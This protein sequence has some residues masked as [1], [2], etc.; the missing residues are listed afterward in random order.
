MHR[1]VLC[2]KPHSVIH[3]SLA[4][5]Q[6]FGSNNSVRSMVYLKDGKLQQGEMSPDD[7]RDHDR[8]PSPQQQNTHT[9]SGVR[10]SVST[11]RAGRQL[12]ASAAG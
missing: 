7:R 10:A 6:H 12:S 5:Q 11:W 4:I 1:L 8:T 2:L 3:R 9:I